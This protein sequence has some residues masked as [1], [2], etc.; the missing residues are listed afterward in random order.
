MSKAVEGE[1]TETGMVW[2][3]NGELQEPR[4]SEHVR[5]P[6]GNFHGT[7][8]PVKLGNH[9]LL[10]DT[11]QYEVAIVYEGIAGTASVTSHIDQGLVLARHGVGHFI[12]AGPVRLTDYSG[13]G[14]TPGGPL[15]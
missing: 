3:R 7:L 15:V 13:C 4:G 14:S 9:L 8:A 10:Q 11:L 5:P 12:L 2:H 1:V 6:T